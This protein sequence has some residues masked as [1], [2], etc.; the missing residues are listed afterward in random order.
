MDFRRTTVAELAAQVG[1]G[2]VSARELAQAALDRIDRYDGELGAF[3]A[4]DGEAALAEAAV[5]DERIAAGDDVGPLAG[6]PLAVKDLEDAAG[7]VTTMGSAAFAGREPAAGDSPLVERLRA[8]GCIVVGKTN[9]PELG[10]KA[11]TT[12]ETFGSTRNPWSPARSPGG[13]SGGS[14]AAVAAGLVPLATGSDG[15]GSIRIPSAVN[16]LSGL[17]SSMGR[18]PV[19]GREAP[20]W[21]LLSTKGPMARRI[22]DV[23]LALDVVVGPEATDLASLPIPEASWSRSLAEVNPPRRVAWAPTLGYARLD[24]EVL[25]VC[26]AAVNRLADL[27][28][29]VIEVETV[30]PDDPLDDWLTLVAVFC[31]RELEPFRDSDVWGSIDPGLLALMEWA[32]ASVTA[33]RVVDAVDACHRLNLALVDL[34]HRTSLLMT[35]TVAGQAPAAGEMMGR[36]DGEEDA[37]WVQMTYG[38]NMTRSPAGT[39]CA[40]FTGDGM[41]VGLQV[42]GPQHADVAVL[43]LLAV[44]EDA[45]DLDPVAPF[46]EA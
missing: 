46:G 29:E 23:A 44:L 42:I 39:V 36:I 24:P 2:E 31:Q 1:G 18:V 3:V 30:F 16:G 26:E 35:P 19:G 14:A 40:G 9:T 43:R 8:A 25:A 5:L 41:P 6:V 13:S 7:F 15:G 38:F 4:V 12:N 20:G 21:P 27:G 37:N 11:D 32:K 45:L 34:F 17:K 10:W 22:R 28:T 33:T